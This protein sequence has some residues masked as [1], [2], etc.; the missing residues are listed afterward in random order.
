M[1]FKLGGVIIYWLYKFNLNFVYNLYYFKFIPYLSVHL[2]WFPLKSFL[3]S[4]L[5]LLFN[6]FISINNNNIIVLLADS[7]VYH[8]EDSNVVR[9]K[10]IVAKY[11]KILPNKKLILTY[12][13]KLVC[14]D[15]PI[16]A[17]V[18]IKFYILGI[19]IN[20]KRQ[21]NKNIVQLLS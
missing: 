8:K 2:R 21:I 9:F 1:I 7:V 6:P 12:V 16:I 20:I 11:Q 14:L 13:S 4:F 17:Q 19:C 5:Y 15:L 18:H 10:L 3:F